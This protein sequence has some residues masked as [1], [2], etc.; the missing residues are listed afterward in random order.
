M[1]FKVILFLLMLLL[2]LQLSHVIPSV[3][4]SMELFAD[5]VG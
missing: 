3:C 1:L 4:I 5:I 2:D